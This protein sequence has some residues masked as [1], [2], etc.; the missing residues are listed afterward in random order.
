[1]DACQRSLIPSSKSDTAASSVPR[2]VRESMRKEELLSRLH[3]KRTSKGS[4]EAK[5]GEG[6]QRP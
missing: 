4:V 1:M 5:R 3:W 6:V 2:M